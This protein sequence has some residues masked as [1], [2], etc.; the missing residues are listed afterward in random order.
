M[1]GIADWD[2][3]HDFLGNLYS[4]P[5]DGT[6]P[7]SFERSELRLRC[8]SGEISAYLAQV[9]TLF[10]EL[11]SKNG[12]FFVQ[13]IDAYGHHATYS[14]TAK[15]DPRLKDIP[16]YWKAAGPALLY[17]KQ[18]FQVPP[19][20]IRCLDIL[21]LAL[22][23][24]FPRLGLCFLWGPSIS[25]DW[26]RFVYCQG[27]SRVMGS[28]NLPSPPARIWKLLVDPCRLW[29][30]PRLCIQGAFDLHLS[31]S[32]I[33]ES[34]NPFSK[35]WKPFHI[36]WHQIIDS[37]QELGLLSTSCWKYGPLYGSKKK[38]V[39][40]EAA[41]TLAFFPNG[42]HIFWHK[43]WNTQMRDSCDNYKR[44]LDF[45]SILLLTPIPMDYIGTNDAYSPLCP[46]FD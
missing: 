25:R 24:L 33:T 30:G 29:P 15:K 34:G 23:R 14:P 38:E 21:A 35:S 39:L 7:L 45:W 2:S 20:P 11:S 22:N 36:T 4:V 6:I 1:A 18:G 27:L 10:K 19:F 32:R 17:E 3:L 26:Y 16:S 31:C 37:T 46:A 13:D 28:P 8:A 41:F 42:N 12:S 43:F 40:Q 5:P 9:Q 44:G